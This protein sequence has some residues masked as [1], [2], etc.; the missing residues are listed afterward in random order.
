MVERRTFALR[1]AAVAHVHAHH[2]PSRGEKARRVPAHILRIRRALK[3]MQQQHRV[4]SSFR[5]PVALAQHAARRHAFVRW[6]YF[7]QLILRRRQHRSAWE[8]ISRQRLQVPIAKKPARREGALP[9]CKLLRRRF[10]QRYRHCASASSTARA[11]KGPS[12]ASSCMKYAYTSPSS[13]SRAKRRVRSC[14]SASLYALR[15]SR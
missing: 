12:G 11:R 6:L 9:P 8:E 5:L 13:A 4:A 3:P 14:R 7:D 10:D 1:A 2:I 15:R